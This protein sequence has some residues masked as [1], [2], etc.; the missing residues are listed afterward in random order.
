MSESTCILV[1][2]DHSPGSLTAVARAQALTKVTGDSLVVCTVLEVKHDDQMLEQARVRLASVAR[3]ADIQVRFG[4]AFVELIRVAREANARLIVAGATGEH[5]DGQLALGV[6]IDRLARKADRP[7][8][9]VRK[10]PKNGY[11]SVIVGL[12]GSTDAAH[13]AHL[14][15]V[16]APQAQITG[17]MAA[18]PIGEHLLTMRGTEERALT[19]YRNRLEEDARERL[20]KAASGLPIDHQQATVGRPETVLLTAADAHESDLLAVGRRGLSPLAAVLLGSV[21]H[22]LVHE[23]PCDVLVYRS[24]DLDFEP[25]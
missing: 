24:S 11:R 10:P 14:A 22:H 16:L 21:G 3:H 25:P 19:A 20:K 7:V 5:T 1:A 23:A 15:R 17:V 6:T 9:V 13:A 4:T 18:P 12:D 2:V 8:L